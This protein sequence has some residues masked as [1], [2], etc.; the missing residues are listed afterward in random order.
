M[1]LSH[2]DN[3]GAVAMD[4]DCRIVGV[5]VINVCRRVFEFILGS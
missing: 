4:R 5:A 3:V 2:G 1:F